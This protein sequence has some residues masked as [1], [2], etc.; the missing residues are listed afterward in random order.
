VD[1]TLRGD[2]DEVGIPRIDEDRRDLFG[3]VEPE[4]LPRLACIDGFVNSIALINAA[5]VIKSPIPA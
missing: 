2:E 1:V 4:V 3:V 5:P